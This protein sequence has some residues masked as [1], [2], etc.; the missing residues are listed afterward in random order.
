MDIA[1]IPAKSYSSRLPNKNI[2]N[3]FGKPIIY[4]AINKAIK[5]KCFKKVF[6]STDSEKIRS[7][8]IKFGADKL[9]LRNTKF[10]KNKTTL[11]DLFSYE[12]KRIKKIYPSVKNICCILPTAL[13]FTIKQIKDS[14]KN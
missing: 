14:K 12:T 8:S 11:L 4:Y 1:I 9:E 10:A 2:K 3:F 7:L 5:S 6:V 13:F